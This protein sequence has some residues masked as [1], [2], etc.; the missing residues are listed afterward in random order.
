MN[1]VNDGVT[2]N[3][4]STS[5]AG[6][7]SFVARHGTEEAQLGDS[8]PVAELAS[9]PGK[10]RDGGVALHARG[11]NTSQGAPKKRPPEFTTEAYFSAKRGS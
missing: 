3:D 10:D 5:I 8:E 4:T 11:R 9:A 6:V 7:A 2:A 1:A